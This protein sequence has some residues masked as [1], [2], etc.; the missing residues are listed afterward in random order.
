MLKRASPLPEPPDEIPGEIVEL[1][2]PIQFT[3]R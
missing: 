3:I 2:I 1:V